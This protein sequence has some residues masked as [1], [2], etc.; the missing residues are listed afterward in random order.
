MTKKIKIGDLTIRELINM[1]CHKCCN[2]PFGNYKDDIL[3]DRL[4]DLVHIF[5]DLHVLDQEIEVE[6]NA[7][8]K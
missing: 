3:S 5:D 4:C 2:C 6:D 7:E 8:S 1:D